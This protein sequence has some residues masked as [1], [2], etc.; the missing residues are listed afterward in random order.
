MSAI[1]L[2]DEIWEVLEWEAEANAEKIHVRIKVFAK[3]IL[4]VDCFL[5]PYRTLYPKIKH[6]MIHLKKL[7]NWILFA[8]NNSYTKLYAMSKRVPDFAKRINL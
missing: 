1:W 6:F 2:W 3:I 8:P 5:I 4:K 7:Q